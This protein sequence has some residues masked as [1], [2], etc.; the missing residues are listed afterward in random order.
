MFQ[1]HFEVLHPLHL[2]QETC[3]SWPSVV[4][5]VASQQQFSFLFAVMDHVAVVMDLVSVSL[6]VLVVT[7]NARSRH[8]VDPRF[9][10]LHLS[11]ELPESGSAE[12]WREV[13]QVVATG[14]DAKMTVEVLAHEI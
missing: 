3:A 7:L 6:L 11:P 5:L 1:A 14:W 8:F 13:Q 9:L 12:L 2:T 4:H 10:N